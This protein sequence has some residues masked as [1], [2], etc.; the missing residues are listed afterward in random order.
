MVTETK[1]SQHKSKKWIIIFVVGVLLGV[2]G[3][4]ITGYLISQKNNDEPTATETKSI[5][6]CDNSD[7]EKYNKPVIAEKPLKD[8]VDE[9]DALY[10]DINS[11]A[12]SSQD[13]TCQYLL[14]AIAF[15]RANDAWKTHADNVKTLN[16]EGKYP[17]NKIYQL[18]DIMS[19]QLQ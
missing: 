12:G 16:T 13:A 18:R 4:G 15:V 3:G 5:V 6:V 14:Y 7:I 10:D 2:L 11:R 19:I 9:W 17:N 1:E 8:Y